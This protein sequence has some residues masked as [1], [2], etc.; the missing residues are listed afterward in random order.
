MAVRISRRRRPTIS[1]IS[2]L[3][4]V[5]G[6]LAALRFH[7][8]W[9]AWA[10]LVLLNLVLG[11]WVFISPMLFHY[12]TNDAATWIHVLGGIAV[13]VVATM[14]MWRIA[15]QWAACEPSADHRALSAALARRGPASG[16]R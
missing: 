15:G 3:L 7:D 6:S 8:R 12:N 14:Q 2:G 9:G 4:V 13:I 1:L 10:N 11:A 16:G 5:I